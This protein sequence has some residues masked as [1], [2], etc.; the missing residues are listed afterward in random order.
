MRCIGVACH[1][2]HLQNRLVGGRAN[3]VMNWPAGRGS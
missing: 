1:N 3:R 2:L